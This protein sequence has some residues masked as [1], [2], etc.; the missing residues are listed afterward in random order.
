[1]LEKHNRMLVELLSTQHPAGSLAPDALRSLMK[2][3]LPVLRVFLRFMQLSSF[4]KISSKKSPI[5]ASSHVNFFGA[6]TRGRR[7]IYVHFSRILYCEHV[8]NRCVHIAAAS[9]ATDM[10]PGV[11][12]WGGGLKAGNVKN[13]IP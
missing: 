13:F 6:S 12:Q 7:R 11:M 3:L 10:L 4:K 9:R 5:D 2:V 8:F 1:M